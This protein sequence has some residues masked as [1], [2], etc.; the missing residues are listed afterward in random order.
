MNNTGFVELASPPPATLARVADRLPWPMLVLEPD[1]SLRHA[2]AAAQALL[3]Q[4]RPL[5][6]TPQQCVRPA[7]GGR[8]GF[9]QALA[10]AA[11][12]RAG[13]VRWTA[14]GQTVTAAFTPLPADAAAPSAVLVVLGL[15]RGR[16][17]QTQAYARAHALTASETRVLEHLAE[18]ANSSTIAAALGLDEAAVRA[19]IVSLRRKTAHADVPSLVRTLA[20]LPPL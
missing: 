9:T 18:G 11:Q 20:T 1:A 12:G 10:Q 4:G 19:R 17:A 15:E 8:G 5:H 14:D 3:D 6:L 16:M 7:T 2:N 13:L